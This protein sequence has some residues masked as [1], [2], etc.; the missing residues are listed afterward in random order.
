MP[1]GA[2]KFDTI[3]ENFMKEMEDN[4]MYYMRYVYDKN[5]NK[6]AMFGNLAYQNGVSQMV[7]SFIKRLY[8]GDENQRHFAEAIMVGALLAMADVGFVNVEEG[9]TSFDPQIFN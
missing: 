7:S 1:K 6:R 8:K 9:Q 3:I 2:D 4:N 5:T